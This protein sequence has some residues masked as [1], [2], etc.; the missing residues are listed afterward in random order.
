MS[1]GRSDDATHCGAYLRVFGSLSY[2]F[3]REQSKNIRA[4]I[5]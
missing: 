4:A 1:S 3:H 5:Y 2:A